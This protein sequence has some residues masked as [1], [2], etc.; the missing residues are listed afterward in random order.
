MQKTTCMTRTTLNLHTRD[1]TMRKLQQT[2]NG[3]SRLN[4]SYLSLQVI[5]E[6]KKLAVL[7]VDVLGIVVCVCSCT[8]QQSLN[9]FNVLL[10]IKYNM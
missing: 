5:D 10:E 4:Y 8:P 2:L 7:I 3:R 9:F 6:K 1:R